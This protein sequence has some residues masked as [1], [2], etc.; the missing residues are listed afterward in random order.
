MLELGSSSRSGLKGPATATSAVWLVFIYLWLPYM[1]LP[2]TPGLERIPTRSWR[3]PPTSAAQRLDDVPAGRSCR[4]SFPAVV[5]GSI[6]TFSLTLGDY[7]VPGLGLDDAVH[8][9]P[10]PRQRRPAGNLPLAA[11]LLAGAPRDHARVPASSPGASAPSR[12]CEHR[13]RGTPRPAHRDGARS[14]AFIYLPLAL[15]VIYAFNPNGTARGRRPGSRS[16]GSADA[17]DNSGPPAGVPDVARGGDSARRSS[18]W[19]WARWPRW[20]WPLRLLRP[21]DRSRSWSSCRSPCRASSP[22]MALSTTFATLGHPAGHVHDHHRARDVLHRARLQQRRRPAAADVAVAGGSLRRTSARTV[23]DVP[24]RDVP[25]GPD[26][27]A[28]PARCWRSPCRST[29]SS[30]RSSRRVA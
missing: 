22:G 7:I 23:A 5:A 26:R 3:R 25:G 17:I 6:F 2:S 10:D 29:R 24:L 30:S 16:S 8:R 13:P 4:S 15:I 11:A 27:A 28:S 14:C 1:I 20:P 18:R 9:Q 21:R 12:R 19:C